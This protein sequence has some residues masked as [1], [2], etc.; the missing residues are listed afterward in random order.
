[1]DLSLH[2][3]LINFKPTKI[4]PRPTNKFAIFF[5]DFTKASITPIKVN[6]D[7]Y[8]DIFKLSREARSPVT[9][10]PI[11]APIIIAAACF[12]PLH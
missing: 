2:E 11:F 10:V 12:N 3:S 1:M 7:K 8:K 4:I 9:V 5:I 6:K